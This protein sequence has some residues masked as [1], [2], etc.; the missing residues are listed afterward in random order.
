MKITHTY[1]VVDL[2]VSEE[3]YNTIREKL[4]AAGY[5]SAV[6]EVNR[7]IDMNGIALVVVSGN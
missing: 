4:L 6:D 3:I 5:N 2:E 7:R 1:T